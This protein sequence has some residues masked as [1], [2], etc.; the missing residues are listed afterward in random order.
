MTTPVDIVRAF[1]QAIADGDGPGVVALLNPKLEWTEAEGFPYYSGTWREPSEVV[2]KLLMPIARDWD[3]F[4]AKADDFV[5]DGDRVIS[6]GAYAGVNKATGKPMHA[7]FAH[8]WGVKDGKLASF[9]MYTDTLI[10]ARA[11]T[12]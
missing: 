7:P 8:I 2:E 4:S 1:Y 6:F 3:D 12:P 11:M 9:R 5:V 10:I